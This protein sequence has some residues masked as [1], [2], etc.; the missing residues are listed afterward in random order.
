MKLSFKKVTKATIVKAY[1][2]CRPYVLENG[3]SLEA[4]LNT[5]TKYI[6][7]GE[8]I[9]I[10]AEDVVVGVIGLVNIGYHSG[11]G[12]A[13]LTNEILKYP[14]AFSKMTKQWMKETVER[15]HVRRVEI[16]VSSQDLEANRWAKFLGFEHEGTLRKFYEDSTNANLLSYVR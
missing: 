10:M 9:A 12:W 4:V 5:C 13:L 14:I 2:N 1:E 11:S 16:I 8:S 7:N 3:N 15:K 6:F